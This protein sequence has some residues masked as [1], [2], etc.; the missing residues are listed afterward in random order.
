MITAE[1]HV[2]KDEPVNPLAQVVMKKL[3]E[4]MAAA[5]EP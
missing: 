5:I 3:H 2:A 1:R 4:R